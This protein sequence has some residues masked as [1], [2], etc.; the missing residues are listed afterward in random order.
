M[1]KSTAEQS[2][3]ILSL[4][5]TSVFTTVIVSIVGK[6]LSTFVASESIS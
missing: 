3:P 2:K 5:F 4:M 1:L 6:M